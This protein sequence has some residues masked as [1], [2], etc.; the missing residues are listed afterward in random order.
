[1]AWKS[2]Y[3]ERWYYENRD[4]LLSNERMR[5]ADFKSLSIDQQLDLMNKLAMEYLHEGS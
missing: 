2:K 5:T 1:M 3:K 4:R